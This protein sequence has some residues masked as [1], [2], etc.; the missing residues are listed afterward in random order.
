M[1][2]SNSKSITLIEL[3]IAIVI[4]GI[5]IAIV[6]PRFASMLV[7]VATEP[8]GSEI[9]P[10]KATPSDKDSGTVDNTTDPALVI[11]IV[12]CMLERKCKNV[13][14]NTTSGGPVT[15]ARV[16]F[17][18]NNK[19][20]LLRCSRNFSDNEAYLAIRILLHPKADHEKHLTISDRGLDGVVDFGSEDNGI[21]IFWGSNDF[22]PSQYT[23]LEYRDIW[24][25][26]YNEAIEVAVR[27][28]L[29]I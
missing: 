5:L 4:I 25:K 11:K 21:K 19:M 10:W 8:I 13:E 14:F 18:Y 26:R 12:D 3:L 22:L 16:I 23:G 24:Q 29:S 15:S 27:Q 17:R 1:R 6:V 20:Y 2:A 7:D 28:L 9:K